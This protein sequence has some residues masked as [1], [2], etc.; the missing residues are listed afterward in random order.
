MIHFSE[1]RMIGHMRSLG[2]LPE[3][4]R[5]PHIHDIWT[6]LRLDPTDEDRG[7]RR[8]EAV[9][10]LSPGVTAGG[11]QAE[12]VARA[13]DV[14]ARYPDTNEGWSVRVRY[15]RDAWI[16][17]VT[18]LAAG[19]QIVLVGF[20]LLL[21]CANVANLMLARASAR[22]Y[23]TVMKGA[24]GATRGGS[25]AKLSPGASCWRH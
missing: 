3:G 14:A 4:C 13:E 16:P 1:I 18:R 8:F 15:L 24:L 2:V 11:A 23:E 5:F 17:P 25:F 12:L 21:V 9:G 20:V 10:R 19:A 6:P 22:R 7:R